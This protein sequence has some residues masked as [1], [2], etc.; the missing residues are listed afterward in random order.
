MAKLKKNY[1]KENYNKYY[2][3]AGNTKRHEMTFKGGTNQT[4][5]EKT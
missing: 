3:T 2:S 5:K 4:L 1:Y